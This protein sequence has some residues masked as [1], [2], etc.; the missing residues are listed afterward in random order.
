MATLPSIRPSLISNKKVKARI[1]QNTFGDGY[2]Q[3]AADGLNSTPS[4]WML[5]WGGRTVSEIDTLEAFFE[6]RGGWDDFDWTPERESSSKKFICKEW[7]RSFV[8][9][10]N[11]TITAKLEEVYDL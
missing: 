7:S 8:A 4:V 3:R 9:N 2:S 11:D 5:T 10:D 1:L 6:A